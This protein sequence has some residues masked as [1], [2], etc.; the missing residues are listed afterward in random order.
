MMKR[1]AAHRIYIRP[2]LAVG[3]SVITLS[4][5]GTVLAIEPF[6]A[7]VPATQW[8]GGVIFLSPQNTLTA[9]E[10]STLCDSVDRVSE[11]EEGMVGS[12]KQPLLAW[13]TESF[14]F[15]KGTLYPDSRLFKLS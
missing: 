12:L 4:N 5:E 8:I 6:S 14:D 13:H 1:F 15:E 11:I 10:A 9:E 3:R 7:E 2:T